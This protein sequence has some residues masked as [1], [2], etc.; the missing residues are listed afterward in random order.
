M[1]LPCL[2]VNAVDF[3][4][5]TGLCSQRQSILG[6]VCCCCSALTPCSPRQPLTYF[7]SMDL[8][9]LDIS[10]KWSHVIRGLLC[11]ALLFNVMFSGLFH[12]TACIR[13]SFL[14]MGE[15]TPLYGPI[16][17]ILFL[18]ASVDGYLGCCHVLAI[19]HNAAMNIPVRVF[20]WR[21]FHCS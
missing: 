8:P 5:S 4:L 16:C 9:V 18:H 1:Q 3:S 17:H 10:Y 11:L 2:S 12:V 21:V 20:V 14:F 19:M 13:T 15:Y 7:L 6:S